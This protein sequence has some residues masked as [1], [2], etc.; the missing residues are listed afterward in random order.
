MQVQ[1]QDA[2]AESSTRRTSGQIYNPQSENDSRSSGRLNTCSTSNPSHSPNVATHDQD[3]PDEPLP[4]IETEPEL[5][6]TLT[7][8]RDSALR[9]RSPSF[10]ISPPPSKNPFFTPSCTPVSKAAPVAESQVSSLDE[11][12]AAL[13]LSRDSTPHQSLS[14]RTASPTRNSTHD[15]PSS[16]DIIPNGGYVAPIS[17]TPILREPDGLQSSLPNKATHLSPRSPSPDIVMGDGAS[18]PGSASRRR[19]GSRVDLTPHNVTEEEPPDATFHDPDFQL[20]LAISKGLVEDLVSILER[21]SLHNEPESRIRGLYLQAVKLSRYQHPSTRTVGLV[22]DTGVGKSS[23]LNSLLDRIGF[24]RTGNSGVACTCVVTEFHYHE[25]AKFA[26]EVEYF[27]REEIRERFTELLRSYRSHHLHEHDDTRTTADHR[28]ALQENAKAA[29]DTFCAAFGNYLAQNE[30]FLLDYPEENVLQTLQTWAVSTGF[31]VGETNT[32]PR[33]EFARAE[34]CSNHLMELTSEPVDATEPSK[35]PFI[36]KIRVYLNAYILSKGLVLVDL[37]GLRDL[38]SARLNIT[39]RYLLECDEIFAVCNIGRATTNPS[40]KEVFELAKRASLS[41]IGIVCTYSDEILADEEE[42]VPD[43]GIRNEIRRLRGNV[44]DLDK[45]VRATEIELLDDT[46]DGDV[47]DDM[48][49]QM[50]RNVMSLHTTLARTRLMRYLVTAR[51]QK[52][53]GEL[54][55]L[56]QNQVP[57]ANLPVF[58]IGNKIYRENRDKPKTEALPYLQLS[59][60]LQVR[61]HCLSLVAEGQLRAATEY[62]TN[63]IPALL[64]SIELWIQAGAGSVGAERKQ[65]IRGALD[66]IEEEFEAVSALAHAYADSLQGQALNSNSWREAAIDATAEWSGWNQATYIAFCR[67][68]GNHETEATIIRRCWNE[69]AMQA[70]VT[71]MKAPWQKFRQD[72]LRLQDGV[73]EAIENIFGRAVAQSAPPGLP[74]N[75]LRTLTVTLRHRKALLMTQVENLCGEFEKSVSILWTDASSG[76]RSSFMGQAMEQSYNTCISDGGRGSD[77]RR[78]ATI[79]SGFGNDQLFPTIQRKFRNGFSK[80]SRDLDAKIQEAVT[81]HLAVVQRDVDTLRN[82]NVVLESE[83]DPK[84]RTLL[85]TEV[86]K[87]RVQLNDAIAVYSR[88]APPAS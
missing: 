65:A 14:R 61:R 7:T 80:L 12:M 33:I 42:Q 87:I 50:T 22:G 40:V 29:K 2:D 55:K 25:N 63:A 77:K 37:P 60:I 64:G 13:G 53:T 46:S 67:K 72:I 47:D 9:A 69:E 57:T 41:N 71:D 26:L 35:W 24:A 68:Y 52:V 15:Q 20:Q 44:D 62:V 19:S 78:K 39:E 81:T 38:N 82:E 32:A 4:S 74:K 28:G 17:P 51:N 10:F 5:G 86:R 76:I 43:E 34:D 85:E 3:D 54:Q 6:P 73:S 45:I 88:L 18:S 70:M 31:P 8:D 27:T 59:G 58:C 30:R 66:R 11:R 16:P 84:F 1:L 36:R 23:L 21:S 48:K 83:S 49:D 56:Y 79:R 75:S